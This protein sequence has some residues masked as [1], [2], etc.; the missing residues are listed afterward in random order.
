MAKKVRYV[1]EAGE[2]NGIALPDLK[3][4]RAVSLRDEKGKMR[5]FAKLAAKYRGMFRG[6]SDLSTRK[7]RSVDGHASSVHGLRMA[8]KTISLEVDAYELLKSARLEH[9]SF[10]Q[11]VRRL[12]PPAPGRAADLLASVKSGKFGR[13]VN[14]TAVE[15][16]TRSRS[17]SPRV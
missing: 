9:E 10:S 8:S 4:V 12:V 11:A 17:R 6:P 2:L 5:D 1:D 7:L 3:K 15:R 13:G 16:A 14:W